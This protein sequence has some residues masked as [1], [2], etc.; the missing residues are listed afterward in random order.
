MGDRRFY[1]YRHIR[2]DTNKPFYV[3]KGCRYR[4]NQKQGRNI[5]W[6]RIADK[7]DY[8]IEIILKDLTEKEA[9]D[10]EMYFIAL[11]KKYNLCEANLTI[12]GDGQSGKD[13]SQFGKPKSD[14]T[15]K[16]ISDTLK[17]RKIPRHIVD[18]ITKSQEKI[19]QSQEYKQK[20][21]DANLKAKNYRYLKESTEKNKKKII[22]SNGVIYNSISEA[23]KVFKCSNTKI[24]Y[25]L[26]GIT[27]KPNNGIYFKF[28][29]GDNDE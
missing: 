25:I 2:L 27:K 19:K 17:G 1:V 11:Y 13:H 28:Y 10:K 14:E 4:A 12:G 29:E 22:D 8:R 5:Y 15:R 20:Q 6:N 24:S 26:H 16:K 9:F 23:A 21:R 18:K 7:T 3:G